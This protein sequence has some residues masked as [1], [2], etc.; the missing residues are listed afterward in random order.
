MESAASTGPQEVA[1]DG[2]VGPTHHYAGLSLGNLASERNRGD[3]ANP[4]AAA[5]QGISKMRT[6]AELGAAQALLP[7]HE[8]P[9]LRGLRQLGFTGD[10]ESVLRRVRRDAPWL[11]HAATSASPMWAANLATVTPSADAGDGRVHFTPANLITMLHRSFEPEMSRRILEVVF[12]GEGFVVHEPLP[13][14]P[15]FSD[16]GAA[17][18]T[19]LVTSLRAL[20]LFGWGHAA[21]ATRKP[22]RFPARQARGASEAI[23]RLHG[24]DESQALLWQQ[25]PGG[26]DAGA[27]HS[28]V[29]CVGANNFFMLHERA[30]V[31]T[32]ALLET[33]RSRL[34]SE[35]SIALA[36]EQELPLSDAVGCYPFNSELL[37]LADGGLVLLGPNESRL[38]PRAHA[39]LQRVVAEHECVKRLVYV[40]V[41]ASMRNGGGPACLRLRVPLTREEQRHVKARLFFDAALG[42]SLESWVERHYRDRL[43]LD[44]LADPALLVETRT[45][46]DELSQLLHLGAL[47]DFQR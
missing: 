2:L 36:S 4:R 42:A 41:N 40:D 47:Y 25:D 27:F 21:D 46:L 26:I 16:E 38:N 33:L 34:G 43:S 17:N 5:L 37:P 19:R 31:E 22:E 20:H 18:H 35:L 23:V 14:H 39:F 29:L 7:P 28:D 24:I 32:P 13:P 11:L 9:Y 12:G 15:L 6:V 1:F 44:D 8:R 3:A 30:F 10:D 45:A